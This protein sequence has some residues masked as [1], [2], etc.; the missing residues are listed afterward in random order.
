MYEAIDKNQYTPMMRQYLE[1][2]EQYQDAIVFFRLGDF[3][4]MFFNDAIV[5]SK[6]L[7]I[8]LTGRD[9]GTT[10][11]VPM[12][13]VPY[14]SVS[15][16]IDKLTA[17]GYKVAIVE[18]VED[19][20]DAKG[21]VK[22]EVIR[23]ITPGT[24]TDGGNISETDNN[25][26]VSVDEAKNRYIL[27]Y[28]DLSTGEN[29][30]TTIPLIGDILRAEILNLRTKEIVISS[31]F[32]QAVLDPL[33]QVTSITI[34]I[35]DNIQ[36][37]NYLKSLSQ[38]LDKEEQIVFNRL[39][40]YVIKTQKRTLVHLQPV[41]KYSID[42]FLKIDFS[43]QRNLELIE[44]LRFQNRKNTLLSVLDK[45]E[46]A[47]GSRLLKKNISFPLV[48]RNEIIGRYDVIDKLHKYFLET[49]E[50]RN[51]LK[52]VYDLER[53]VGRISYG[54][55]NPRD[56][57]QL[58]KSLNTIP[59]IKRRLERMKLHEYFQLDTYYQ[60]YLTIYQLI[61]KSIL[62]DA[63]LTIKEGNIIKPGFN[64]ELDE[65]Q[66]MSKNNKEYLLNLE[67]REQ[68]RTGIRNLKVGF[69]RV[70]G[71]YI[72]VTKSNIPL[73]KEEFGYIR[74]Q[75]LT[76]A[77]RYITE[78][79]KEKETQILRAEEK[80]IELEYNLFIEIRNTIKNY[81]KQLQFLA[82]QLAKLD[83]LQAFA[84]VSKENN[85]VRPVI[86]DKSMINIKAGRHPVIE[87]FLDEPFIA[88]DLYMDEN[89]SVILITGPNMSGKSTFMR[90]IALIAIMAQIGCFVPA[91]S[92][93]IPIFDA[94][95]TRIGAADD[96]VSGQSTFMVEMMEVN[97]A[98][99]YA[100][101]RSL[102]L[103]DEIGRGT[104]T[105][106]GMALAQ[107]I[108][109]YVHEKIKCKTL[110]S[111][112]YHELTA[113]EESLPNLKNVHVS[114][115]EEKGNVVFVHKVLPGAIDKSYGINVAKLAKLPDE[116]ILRANDLLIKLEQNSN[117]D[118]KM[119]IEHYVQPLIF[120][121][122]T[123]QEQEVIDEIKQLNLNQTSPLEALNILDSLQKKLK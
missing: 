95:F 29:Y 120:D 77:E 87:H 80:S 56:L 61:D 45:C 114:A 52:D 75:T 86:T 31:T 109:E 99:K 41:S 113:L 122:K 2:K 93:E 82:K 46:T 69:N 27:A 36:D 44:T 117:Y 72:E 18:Q 76:N 71:Y 74:K 40:N 58:K 64:K 98:L 79:L 32:N 5:A 101:N 51:Y 67:A 6:E 3:Y 111:T 106:D 119:S 103:F 12:C 89:E 91:K 121:S 35:E 1:I 107:A 57:L 7:E 100:T 55:A 85:Y 38:D 50:I 83:M 14:H 20:K 62:E 54:N 22:R 13:G 30:L 110:F 24:I 28:T 25:F 84:R 48:D 104:A 115:I 92:A 94:I 42:G 11:R 70:F 59:S 65:L 66:M 112:H 21:I 33:K 68:E 81:T 37:V 78:E 10:E 17:K 39:I 34:S 47:M 116:V 8:V 26:L 73:I 4:E 53:I 96:I 9:A 118:K 16:Y 90:Q 102:I 123:P 43:S 15:S 88:N 97:N 108:I 49:S 60:D 23:V 19:P 63:P 105:F